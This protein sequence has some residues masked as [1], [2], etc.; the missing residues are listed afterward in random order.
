MLDEG[1]LDDGRKGMSSGPRNARA[2]VGGTL[3]DVGVVETPKPCRET[4]SSPP[5]PLPSPPPPPP[6]T[7]VYAR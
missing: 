6:T 2:R 4:S 1:T 3:T 7:I 5:P